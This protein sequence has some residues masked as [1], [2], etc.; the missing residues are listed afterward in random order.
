M[1]IP[2]ALLALVAILVGCDPG[3]VKPAEPAWN[4]QACAHCMM[5]LS[6]KRTAAS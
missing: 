6:D 1:R 5:L 3:G 4:K 2:L